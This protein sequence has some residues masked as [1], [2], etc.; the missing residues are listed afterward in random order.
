MDEPRPATIRTTSRPPAFDFQALAVSARPLKIRKGMSVEEAYRATLLG[1][2]AHVTANVTAVMHSR[3]VEGLHQL[4]V[5]LRRLAVA[6]SAFGE[7]FQTPEQRALLERTKAFSSKIAP[8]RDLDVF[9]EQLFEPTVAALGQDAAFSLLR[10]RLGQARRE[11]WDQVVE[12][13]ASAEFTSLHN[14]VAQ[15]A[16]NR[17]WTV[18]DLTGRSVMRAPVKSVAGL[19]LD[20]Y[21]VKARKRG[22][23]LKTLEQRDCHRLRISLKKLRYAAEFY[24]PLF[25]KKKVKTYIGHL[26]EL[27]DILGEINDSG[28]VRAILAQLTGGD[29]MAP[30]VEAD[31]FFASGLINGWHRAR[32]ARLGK[33]ALKRWDDFRRLEPFWA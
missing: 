32:A 16:Q 26:K 5:G 30:R 6:F 19:R 13:V 2:H 3:E 31:L 28:Q 17:A 25:R 27:Q 23:H 24:G 14:D 15:A 11:A 20:E 1:C 33:S 18:S 22:R 4:R 8:A 21:L 7:E 10:E 29:A 12:R 9:T